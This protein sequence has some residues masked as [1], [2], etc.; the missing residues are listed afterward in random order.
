MRVLFVESDDDPTPVSAERFADRDGVEVERAAGW[1]AAEHDAGAFD[2][3]V[4]NYALADGD[5]VEVVRAV[6]AAAPR[7][8]VV[9]YTAVGD[10]RV[11][12]DALRAGAA[13][14]VV[15]GE[16]DDRTDGESDE[17]GRGANADGEEA[18]EAATLE[19][20]VR[21]AVTGFDRTAEE[22][23]PADRAAELEALDRLFRHDI[24]N[25]IAVIVGWA[26]VL[27]DHVSEEGEEILD[28]ILDNGRHTLELTDV[29]G[30]AAATVT[31]DEATAVEPTDL[32]EALR[33]AVR[34]RRE[35]FPGATIE[36]DA[37]P[38][39][40][41]AAN[42]LLGSVF[43]SLLNDAVS[44]YDGDAPAL[45][46][47]AE[48]DGGTVRVRMADA[49]PNGAG[50]RAEPAFGTGTDLERSDAGIDRYLVERLV[51]IYGGR[52][53]VEDGAFVVELR[54]SD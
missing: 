19:R 46:V 24:R 44:N 15:A 42:Y 47:S 32:G 52:V 17:P 41:V 50:V 26:D 25:D 18:R 30:D 38:T 3:V 27:R 2:C 1:V 20:R 35:A 16:A 51:G 6:G 28:R 9:L 40:R 7:L 5:G 14:Y 8:P 21:E 33:E 49:D 31:D 54:A 43:R 39:C 37:V 4:T 48:R 11:A 36:L 22:C 53:K 12:R 45:R 13:D 10:E 29:A 34:S 23:T